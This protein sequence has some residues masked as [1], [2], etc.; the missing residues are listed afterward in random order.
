MSINNVNTKGVLGTQPISSDKNLER[1][2]ADD[3]KGPSFKDTLQ[4]QVSGLDKVEEKADATPQVLKFSNH[5]VER[6][7]QRGITFSP[8]Q[9][10][11]IEGAARKAQE[12]GAKEA[13][14]FTDE[15]ALIVSL[16]NS[17]VVTVMDKA[18]LKEN[19]FTNID[20]T[21]VV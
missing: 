13:L 3:L 4:T 2:T 15:S 16:K 12:K 6:M 9:M 8:E 14:I 5:A 10:T 19:V 1:I 11:K 17:T 21:V 18:N 7:S 20:S